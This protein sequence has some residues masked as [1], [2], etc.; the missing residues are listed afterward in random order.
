M[1]KRLFFTLFFLSPSLH[2]DSFTEIDLTSSESTYQT[3]YNAMSDYSQAVTNQNEDLANAKLDDALAT[4]EV[5]GSSPTY[6]KTSLEQSAVHI[7]ET[8]DRLLT[9]PNTP[10]ILQNHVQGTNLK[11]RKVEDS[12][13]ISK[14][15]LER[16]AKDY[17]AVKDR[18]Y[19]Q[20]TNPGAKQNT[21]WINKVLPDTSADK[22]FGLTKQKWTF[23]G[24][25]LVAAFFIYYFVI[26]L[27]SLIDSLFFKEDS[28]NQNVFKALIRPFALI[29]AVAFLKVV[30][31]NLQ[32]LGTAKSVWMSITGMI[33]HHTRTWSECLFTC[34][35]PWSWWTCNST[36]SQR[37]CS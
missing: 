18:P 14:F 5:D 4:F 25:S 8:L 24:L 31:Q 28:F 9:D 16:A 15:S 13:Y 32:L 33:D 12:V 22:H 11:F 23:L 27:A 21:T 26:L 19:T 34:C 6:T 20:K 17:E 2:A 36:R 10:T 3:F 29:F 35:R 1:K 37:H 7:K 30:G